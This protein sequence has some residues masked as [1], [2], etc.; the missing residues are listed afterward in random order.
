M[1]SELS[2]LGSEGAGGG[3]ANSLA[4]LAFLSHVGRAGSSDQGKSY[5]LWHSAQRPGHREIGSAAGTGT[6]PLQLWFQ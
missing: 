6:G 2:V 1:C 3:G 4:L 5:R